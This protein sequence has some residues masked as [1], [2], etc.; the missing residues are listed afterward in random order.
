MK[1][2]LLVLA[3]AGSIS[4]AFA[5]DLLPHKEKCGI[6]EST[7]RRVMENPDLKN[8]MEQNEQ[9]LQQLI[10]QNQNSRSSNSVYTIPVV[11]HVVWRLGAQNISDAQILS[12][13]D[14]LNEDFGHR[15]SDTSSIPTAWRTIS[16]ASNFQFCMA[17]QDENGNATNGIERRQTTVSSFNTNDNV[18]FYSTGGLDAWDT[19]RFFNI[20]VCNLSGGIIGYA[21]FPTSQSSNTYGVVIMYDSFGRVGNVAYPYDEGRTATHEIGH[22]F[23]LKHIWGDDAGS[24]SGTD[25]VADTPNQGSETYGCPTY[26]A[27]D[28]CNSSSTGY[29]FM[30]YMDYSDDRCLYMFTNGQNTRMN[31]AM[32]SWYSD[33]LTSGMCESPVGIKDGPEDFQLSVYPN[34]SEGIFMLDMT[35]TRDLG[36]SINLQVIDALG[37]IVFSQKIDNP[38]GKI[39]PVDMRSFSEGIYLLN[40]SN[41]EFRKTIRVSRL[42]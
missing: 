11:V 21:E 18:K 22:C 19:R 25:N 36:Q 33:L 14:V 27:N 6:V 38:V 9:N 15:N 8:L 13:I 34:P 39:H 35:G 29:M 41:G 2:K 23:N 20:W 32:T 37:K 26:P 10:A 42:N 4:F 5:G 28:N 16:S 40:L 7:K 1:I 24:C 12:Q 30:N 31:T 17:R 3:I